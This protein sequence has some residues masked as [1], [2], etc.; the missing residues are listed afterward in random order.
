VHPIPPD[1]GQ[2]LALRGLAG[3]YAERPPYQRN[4][5]IAWIERARRE[6]TRTRRMAQMLDELAGGGVYMGMAWH[7][8]PERPR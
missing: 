7:P 4:D 6:E 5:Y 3:A 8:A 1:V 2:A